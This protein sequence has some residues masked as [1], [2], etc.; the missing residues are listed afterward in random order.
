MRKRS[1][2][3][4][5]ACL[6]G[7]IALLSACGDDSSPVYFYSVIVFNETD[8]M[9]TVR[10]DWDEFLLLPQ[11]LGRDT[12]AANEN[13]ILEWYSEN[14]GSEWI[15]VEYQGKRVLFLADQFGAVHV[16]MQDLQ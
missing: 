15:E 10:Y 3:V 9:I 5:L 13:K 4:L 12:I 2:I 6:L 11:W 14:Q 8:S 16:T 1:S 7:G